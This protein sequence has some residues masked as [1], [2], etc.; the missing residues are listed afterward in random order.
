MTASRRSGSTLGGGTSYGMR[1]SWILRFA[2]TSRCAMVGG[3]TR[4]ARAIS[5]VDRPHSVR[6]DSATCASTAS[7]GWQQVKISRSR[8]S[9]M[10]ASSG[11]G[12]VGIECHLRHAA[13]LGADDREAAG[14]AQHVDRLVARGRDD[15]GARVGRAPLRGH[16]CERGS[17]RVLHRLLG[18]VEVADQPDDGRQ[19]AAELVAVEA[20]DLRRLHLPP[21][22]GYRT[23]A[24]M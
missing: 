13:E 18:D 1:A 17:E 5:S 9:G 12:V 3:G 6:S 20:L 14:P 7:A 22:R 11:S 10:A 21:R 2:R 16:C 24:L 4:K 15:P 19:D 8:S 23:A